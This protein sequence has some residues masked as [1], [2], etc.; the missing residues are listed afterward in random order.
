MTS[1]LRGTFLHSVLCSKLTPKADAA[2][3]H[4]RNKG[5]EMDGACGTYG[6]Q[7]SSLQ[8]SGEEP[9]GKK[10]FGRPRRKWKY[11]IKVDLK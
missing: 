1:T 3:K 8:G 10:S 4:P 6:G 11:N 5:N 7:E 2:Y 9:E